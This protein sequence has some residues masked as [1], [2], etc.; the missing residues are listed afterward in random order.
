MLEFFSFLRPSKPDECAR[1]FSRGEGDDTD[2]TSQALS[3][4][5]IELQ[6]SHFLADAF[7]SQLITESVSAVQQKISNSMSI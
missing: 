4:I 1:S 6:G 3:V 5:T 7:K 2:V